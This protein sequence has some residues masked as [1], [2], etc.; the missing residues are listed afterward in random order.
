MAKAQEKVEEWHRQAMALSKVIPSE[1]VVL[2]GALSI[3]EDFGQQLPVLAELSS[4]TLKHKHWRNI[5]KGWF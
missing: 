2:Q 5:F 3:M 1:D 4:P